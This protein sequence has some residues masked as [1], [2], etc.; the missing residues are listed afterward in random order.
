MTV[1]KSVLDAN[2]IWSPK[3]GVM[4]EAY[5]QTFFEDTG[6]TIQDMAVAWM[7]TQLIGVSL[8][9]GVKEKM[10]DWQLENVCTQII[11]E[12]PK[13]TLIEFILFCARL[14]S[15]MYEEFYGSVD[16]M[17]ILKSFNSFIEDKKRDYWKEYDIR[18]E[19]RKAREAEEDRKK[20]MS[21][22]EFRKSMDAGLFPNLAKLEEK[23]IRFMSPD[24]SPP[25][26][27]SLLPDAKP[28]KKHVD[29][30]EKKLHI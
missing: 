7:K 3:L 19:K 25:S 2:K 14:R 9:V 12:H 27:G 8:F 30:D 20:A 10:S 28:K 23:G 21:Y 13:T 11:S 15:G 6:E 1:C 5:P 18:E 17:Q 26:L 29:K 16:P 22:D 24:G 4:S